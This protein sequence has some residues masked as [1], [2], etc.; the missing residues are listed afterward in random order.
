M[1]SEVTGAAAA[2]PKRT[3]RTIKDLNC[4]FG[5]RRKWGAEKGEEMGEEVGE[6]SEEKERMRSSSYIYI[7]GPQFGLHS[8]FLFG[9]RKRRK[10]V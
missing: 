9:E 1:S 2:R 3:K 6:D 10:L 7:A 8:A 4:I 5:W